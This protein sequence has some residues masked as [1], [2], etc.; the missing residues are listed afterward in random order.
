MNSLSS[1]CLCKLYTAYFSSEF[2]SACSLVGP[3][4][5]SRRGV[6]REGP[7]SG[8]D[9]L[10]GL[11]HPSFRLTTLLL[12]LS[13]RRINFWI[14]LSTPST[15]QSLSRH[16]GYKEGAAYGSSAHDRSA[17]VLFS[18]R[19]GPTCVARAFALLAYLGDTRTNKKLGEVIPCQS[20][21]PGAR[22]AVD[23][24]IL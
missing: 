11:L 19:F 8:A 6:S 20:S 21:S 2:V 23:L 1:C 24:T 15:P 18:L 9:Q 16:I 22:S 10:A 17:G 14:D 5:N 7:W 12:W 3:K 13:G 4:Q